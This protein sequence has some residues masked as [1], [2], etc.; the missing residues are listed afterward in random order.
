MYAVPWIKQS[1]RVEAFADYL[2]LRDPRWE[3]LRN[4]LLHAAAIQT[5]PHQPTFSQ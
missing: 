3:V 1:S 2:L 5:R 4:G